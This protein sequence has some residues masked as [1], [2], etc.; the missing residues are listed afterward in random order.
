M[1]HIPIIPRSKNISN[2]P[3]IAISIIPVFF[4]NVLAQDAQNVTSNT[5]ISS[6]TSSTSNGQN[7]R[8]DSLENLQE[9]HIVVAFTIA[10]VILSWCGCFYVFYRTYKQWILDKKRLKMIHRLPFYTAF[11]GK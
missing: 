4:H 9:F 1:I 2:H 5:T 10:M 3:F 6:N 11:S 8:L 7:S